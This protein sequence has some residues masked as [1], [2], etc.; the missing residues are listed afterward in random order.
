MKVSSKTKKI[1]PSL[2]R[3]LFN[4]AQEY[5]DVIDLL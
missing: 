5:D 2:T 1:T 4:M 3:K